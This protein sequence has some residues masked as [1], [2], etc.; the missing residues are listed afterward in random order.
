MN[1]SRRT[2]LQS[3]SAGGVALALGGVSRAGEKVIQGFEQTTATKQTSDKWE[4]ISDRKIRV[5]LVGHGVCKFASAFGFQDH[6]NVEVVAVS[7]LIPDR[8]AE[9]SKVARCKKTYPSIEE[10]V[11]DD[12]DRS[13]IRRDGCAAARQ[14]LHRS[15]QARQARRQ[16]RPGVLRFTGRRTRIV[17]GGEGRAGMKYMMFET[18]C[19]HDDLYAMRQLYN[20]GRSE[21]S[22]TPRVST[23]TSC[24]S[25]SIRTKG[26]ELGC[27]RSF[28]RHTPTPI[29]SE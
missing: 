29:T 28:I 27:R 18:S 23:T 12:N 3:V 25:R 20:A 19:F 24:P 9:L 13:S 15:A 8:C 14:T 6:P 22:C 1:P 7:D 2:L 5:G 21:K 11:K 4:P 10:M 17:R 16:R 26:G